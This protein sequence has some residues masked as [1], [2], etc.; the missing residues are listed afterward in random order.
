M[1]GVKG[2]RLTDAERATLR[3]KSLNSFLLTSD[4]T[5]YGLLGGVA[6]ASCHNIFS[7][8]QMDTEHNRLECL[9]RRLVALT[10]ELV[11]ELKKA[12]YKDA[13]EVTVKLALTEGF[14]AAF[15]PEYRLQVSFYPRTA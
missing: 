9:E 7:V 11:C 10:D 2:K 3:K 14:Y 8:M 4:G 13:A 6:M 1:H 15:F 5:T 12:G